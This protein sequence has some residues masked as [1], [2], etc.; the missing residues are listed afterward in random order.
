MHGSTRTAET[1]AVALLQVSVE[2]DEK[3]PQVSVEIDEKTS[4]SFS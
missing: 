3:T 4:T 1:F 2:I